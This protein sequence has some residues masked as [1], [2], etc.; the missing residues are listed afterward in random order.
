MEYAPYV[1]MSIFA[2]ALSDRWDK[3][4]VMLFSDTFAACSTMVVLVLFLAGVNLVA[5]AFDA[6][7]PAYVLSRENGGEAVL[8]IVTSCAGL[9]TLLGSVVTTLMPAPKNRVRD[10]CV[11]GIRTNI[12]E[13]HLSGRIAGS[14]RKIC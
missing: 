3:K 7:L 13:I 6:V 10:A 12:E 14:K 1:L 4:K 2:G 8:G 5:S 9:A 11:S